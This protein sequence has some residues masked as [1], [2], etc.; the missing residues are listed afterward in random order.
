MAQQLV[1][2]TENH[3]VTGSIPGLA[4]WVK[5]QA[6]LWLWRKPAATAPN[7]PLTWEPPYA[8]GV[9]L[10]RQKE[11]FVLIYILSLAH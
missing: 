7:G 11:N 1:N 2:P 10:I 6:L 5:D 3:K 8:A 4:Q 9:A